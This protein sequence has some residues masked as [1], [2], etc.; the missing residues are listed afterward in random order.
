MLAQDNIQYICTVPSVS[1][2]LKI[3]YL[4]SK[5]LLGYMLAIYGLAVVQSQFVV[6]II[7][8]VQAWRA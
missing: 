4:A 8:V 6:N 5:Q 3:I 1:S 2:V 7:E